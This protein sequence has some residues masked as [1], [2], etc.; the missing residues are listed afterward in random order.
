MFTAV[1][2]TLGFEL[3]PVNVLGE[4]KGKTTKLTSAQRHANFTSAFFYSLRRILSVKQRNQ[5]CSLA[6]GF[7]FRLHFIHMRTLIL[8]NCKYSSCFKKAWDTADTSSGM[9]VFLHPFKF[10][11]CLF[12][13]FQH[14]L[15]ARNY[16]ITSL[17][18]L[19]MPHSQIRVYTDPSLRKT[20]FKYLDSFSWISTFWL[21]RLKDYF[22]ESLSLTAFKLFHLPCYANYCL[23][24][25]PLNILTA[26]CIFL[27]LIVRL[28]HFMVHKAI[29]STKTE[30][31]NFVLPLLLFSIIYFFLFLFAPQDGL[32]NFPTVDLFGL[33]VWADILSNL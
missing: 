24:A 3:V 23:L 11:S 18:S 10:F 29:Y 2:I 19:D 31:Y 21:D 30:M 4:E 33:H 9:L 6:R 15:Y 16:I 26:H 13:D 5:V 27:Y 20:V 1:W 25:F 7:S 12:L 22:W 8:I 32:P 17:T 14:L 28:Q